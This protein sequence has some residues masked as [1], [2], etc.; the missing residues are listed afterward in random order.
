MAA[1]RVTRVSAGRAVPAMHSAAA[2]DLFGGA[3]E[4]EGKEGL[5]HMFCLCFVT[6]FYHDHKEVQLG[7][8]FLFIAPPFPT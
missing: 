5:S 4:M 2:F 8:A 6:L 3:S 1:S 7:E